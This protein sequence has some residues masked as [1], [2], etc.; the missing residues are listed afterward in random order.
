MTV[1]TRILSDDD[2]EHT[3]QSTISMYDAK[4]NERPHAMNA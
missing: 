4:R 3:M 1:R 2:D